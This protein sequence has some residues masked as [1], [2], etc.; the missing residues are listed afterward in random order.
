MLLV[1]LVGEF[2]YLSMLQASSLK[3]FIDMGKLFFILFSVALVALGW[4]EEEK[5]QRDVR[6]G[7]KA[8]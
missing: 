8:K 1:V 5:A 6:T 2:I 3:C 4:K 7:R